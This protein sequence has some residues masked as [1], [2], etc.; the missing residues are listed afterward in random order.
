MYFKGPGGARLNQFLSSENIDSLERE[1]AKRN[2]PTVWQEPNPVR[3]T[4][5]AVFACSWHSLGSEMPY[6]IN[7]DKLLL[8]VSQR[9]PPQALTLFFLFG[10]LLQLWNIGH[11]CNLFQEVGG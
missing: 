6:P 2:V 1:V 4:P 5:N 3:P 8:R 7:T 9:F 10:V 11:Q